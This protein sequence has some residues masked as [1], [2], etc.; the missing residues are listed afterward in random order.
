MQHTY[1][2]IQINEN[3][4]TIA[5]ASQPTSNVSITITPQ[6]PDKILPI[7]FLEFT[8]DNYNQPQLII[9]NAIPI[10]TLNTSTDI[11][12]S[13]VSNDVNYNF[14]NIIEFRI[15]YGE[16]TVIIDDV[17]EYSS[18]NKTFTVKLSHKPQTQHTQIPIQ[19]KADTVNLDIVNF[20]FTQQNWQSGVNVTID[21]INDDQH[22][23]NEYIIHNVYIIPATGYKNNKISIKVPNPNLYIKIL[24]NGSPII[25]DMVIYTRGNTYQVMPSKEINDDINLLTS[26][27]NKCENVSLDISQ[28]RFP[29]NTTDVITVSIDNPQ[30]NEFT[31]IHTFEC[32]NCNITRSIKV[33][34]EIRPHFHLEGNIVNNNGTLR[35]AFDTIPSHNIRLQLDHP[36]IELDSDNLT[37][38]TVIDNTEYKSEIEIPNNIITNDIF[39][40]CQI[41]VSGDQL[42]Y[43]INSLVIDNVS[44]DPGNR[45]YIGLDAKTFITEQKCPRPSNS[46]NKCNMLV[47][48]NANTCYFKL[49]Q[50]NIPEIIC[51]KTCAHHQ[52]G[53]EIV[54]QSNTDIHSLT[55]NYIPKKFSNSDKKFLYNDKIENKNNNHIEILDQKCFRLPNDPKVMCSRGNETTAYNFFSLDQEFCYVDD[56]GIVNCN[57][58]ELDAKPLE[59]LMGERY[60]YIGNESNQAYLRCSDKLKAKTIQCDD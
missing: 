38:D 34:N 9:V 43:E 21:E 41:T 59:K 24:Q 50:A 11:V 1:Q 8:P 19:I 45:E 49:N 4:Y 40:L 10:I 13:C 46:N 6:D 55:K 31:I 22:S 23:N 37:F 36:N 20:A 35:I 15:N 26:F 54:F 58:G 33:V 39:D 48:K 5:L 7:D 12:F 18:T 44:S 30:Q 32:N 14:E 60:C 42:L 47:D 57:A 51:D 17:L 56:E 52:F 28:E 53:K 16:P 27:T 3:E 2:Y 25:N 29:A